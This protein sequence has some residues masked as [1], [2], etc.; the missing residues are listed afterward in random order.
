MKIKIFAFFA[1]LFVTINAQ[2][3]K[4]PVAFK[5]NFLQQVTNT[6]GKVIKYRG[7]IY[8][9]SP[10]RTKWIYKS[11]TR[12]EVCTMGRKLT[13]IDHDLEQVSYYSINK[14][15]NLS[16]VL[17]KARLHKGNTYVTTYNGK[18]YTIVLDNKGRVQQIAY[19]DNLDNTVNIIFTKIKY[20]NSLLPNSKFVCARPKNYDTIY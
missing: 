13:V 14:G 20:R 9:N 19:K 17:K 18:Y 12:K 16:K 6:K 10:S 5:A 1:L 7:R 3:I 11:P 4:L 15:F 8:Y 2:N